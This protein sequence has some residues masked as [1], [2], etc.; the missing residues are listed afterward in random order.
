[1]QCLGMSDEMG[2]QLLSEGSVLIKLTLLV[3]L[4]LR[5]KVWVLYL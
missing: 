2:F 3:K 5:F 4:Y 1:M